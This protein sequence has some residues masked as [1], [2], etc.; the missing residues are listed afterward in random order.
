MKRALIPA[1]I[2]IALSVA[3]ASA[4]NSYLKA[5]PSEPPPATKSVPAKVT[6]KAPTI[7]SKCQVPGSGKPSSC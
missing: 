1:A 4:Q 5:A 7:S 2:L 3:G 6:K